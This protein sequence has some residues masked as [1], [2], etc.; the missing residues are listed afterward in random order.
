MPF[1]SAYYF[2]DFAEY[3]NM[4]NKNKNIKK[5]PIWKFISEF[6]VQ[7]R[8]DHVSSHA[9]SCAFFI[10]LSL[11]PMTILLCSLLQFVP[12][13]KSDLIAIVNNDVPE[14]LG[15]ILVTMINESVSK[16]IGTVSIAAITTL[17][18]AGKGVN[19]LVIG[20][21]EV[22]GVESPRNG[23][24]QR[25]FACL[26][27]LVFLC[28]IVLF[29][30]LF[31]YGKVLKNFLVENFPELS[32]VFGTIMI[33]RSAIT[34]VI[35]TVLLMILYSV[36]P[37]AKMK[38]KAQFL[39]AFFTAT[40]WIVFSYFFSLYV[41]S[42]NTFSLY[43][44]FTTIIIMCFWLFYCM[45]FV[46]IGADLN[47]YFRPLLMIIDKKFAERHATVKAQSESLDE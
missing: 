10:F 20:L 17:W 44:S 46:F 21:N 8:K 30:V 3:M 29:L 2:F 34:L 13:D 43:G 35:M 36:L 14:A 31:V 32:H 40:T 39:G 23:I 7:L 4:E 33:F 27:T 5:N 22:E 26:Y 18:A 38:I 42:R 37:N 24:V 41:G 45:Y 6:G 15:N 19:A 9:A 11:M 47:K 25:L 12:A 28:A 16:R 1:F